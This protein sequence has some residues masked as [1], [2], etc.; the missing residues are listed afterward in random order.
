MKTIIGLSLLQRVLASSNE[1]VD[2]LAQKPLIQDACPSNSILHNGECHLAFYDSLGTQTVVA[3]ANISHISHSLDES[4]RLASQIKDFPWTFWPE[5][6]STEETIEPYCVFSD[7]NFASGRGIFI[8]TTKTFAYSMLEKDA[9]KNPKSLERMNHYENPPF[10]QHEFP[11]KGRGLVAN[12]T[13]H[14]GDQIFAS[15]PLLLSDPDAYELPD[16]ERLALLYRG[17]ETL[18]SASRKLFWDLLGHFNDDPV[19]DRIN[20]NNFETTVDGVHQSAVFPE[21]AM[22]NHDCRPNAAYF[23]DEATLTHFVHATRTIYPGEEI[24]ITY[25]DNEM[26]RAKRMAKLEKHWGFKCSCSACTAHPSLTAESDARLNEMNILTK[27]LNDWTPTSAA[28]PEAA[29]LLISLYKQ[30]RLYAGL[31]TA[32]KHAAEVYSSFGRKLE[33]IKY[34]R[35]STEVGML[36]KGFRD[37]DVQEMKRMSSNPEMSWSWNKRLGSKGGCGCGHRH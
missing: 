26:N 7:E 4:R 21:I 25:I 10:Q 37:S 33:A 11:G 19:E 31:S 12:K 20:T 23:F 27:I 22:L 13:L 32:Y 36:D 6:F 9:F 29:E 14:A 15:T 3:A 34:A 5:C 24:T 1:K 17:V 8:I 16:S 2:I 35:L 28:T 30:E 18:P